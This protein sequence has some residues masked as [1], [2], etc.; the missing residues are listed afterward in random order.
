MRLTN[1]NR[2]GML[3]ISGRVHVRSRARPI[4]ETDSYGC[5]SWPIAQFS[6]SA[7]AYE[8]DWSTWK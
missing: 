5:S 8:S 6:S 7:H 1:N 2:R 3:A 4:R